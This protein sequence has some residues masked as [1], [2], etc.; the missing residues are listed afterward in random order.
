MC[1]MREED[2]L[3]DSLSSAKTR[4]GSA[5]IR[6][7]GS[8]AMTPDGVRVDSEV[9]NTPAK[10][11]YLLETLQRKYQLDLRRDSTLI[12]VNGV[13]AGALDDLETVVVSG[14]DV[15]LIPMFH[16]G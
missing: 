4:S 15:V 14:D 2:T 11:G 3:R 10:L 8:L 13:E 16:G 7:K 12:I 9:V 5:S 1:G 6:I